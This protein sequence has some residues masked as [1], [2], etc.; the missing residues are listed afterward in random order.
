MFVIKPLPD[1]P[2][3]LQGRILQYAA[4]EA[5]G[6]SRIQLMLISK[7]A[8]D[9]SVQF[10]MRYFVDFQLTVL[11]VSYI[12]YDTVIVVTLGSF[13]SFLKVVESRGIEFLSAR[14]HALFIKV[15]HVETLPLWGILLSQILPFLSRMRFLEIWDPF[16]SHSVDAVHPVRVAVLPALQALPR[17]SYLGIHPDFFWENDGP[18]YVTLPSISHLKIFDTSNSITSMLSSLKSFPSLTHFMFPLE[19]LANPGTG[20]ALAETLTSLKV[21]IIGK[22]LYQAD[23]PT[24][25]FANV[26][27]RDIDKIFRDADLIRFKEV[28]EDSR[29]NVWKLAEIEIFWRPETSLTS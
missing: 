10:I 29:V 23:A 27:V 12:H 24:G 16:V 2:V 18:S 8:H 20:L 26:V 25:R 22:S 5:H 3:E 21:V 19:D 6:N 14:V 28:A 11:R 1:L 7:M 9:W 13:Q 15:K 17:L 4:L